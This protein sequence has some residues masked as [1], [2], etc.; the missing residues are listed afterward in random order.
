MKDRHL[1]SQG[2]PTVWSQLEQ[3]ESKT[4]SGEKGDTSSHCQTLA[5]THAHTLI[6]AQWHH[7]VPRC[8]CA[9]LWTNAM[10]DSLAPWE[11]GRRRRRRRKKRLGLGRQQGATQ[12]PQLQ[13]NDAGMGETARD[14]SPATS[15]ESSSI[16]LMWHHVLGSS[17]Y[18]NSDLLA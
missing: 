10:N 16:Q 15:K 14:S 4:W 8:L 3:N 17:V 11:L 1:Q 2:K 9:E 6:V 13:R 12:C 7:T 5:H 18:G